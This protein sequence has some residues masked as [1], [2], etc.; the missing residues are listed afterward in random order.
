MR[1]VY[2]F[3]SSLYRS[4]G[5]MVTPVVIF[6]FTLFNSY[7]ARSAVLDKKVN[8]SISME[9]IP[10]DYS[11]FNEFEGFVSAVLTV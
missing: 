10:G 11:C 4:S 9:N 1:D 6:Y 3:T 5:R 7:A 8:R 2:A